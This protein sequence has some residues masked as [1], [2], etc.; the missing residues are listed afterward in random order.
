[1]KLFRLSVA[2]AAVLFATS[3]YPQNAAYRPPTAQTYAAAPGASLA[4][5]ANSAAAAVAQFLSNR[6]RDVSE[7]SLFEVSTSNALNN[8]SVVRFE[9]RAGGLSI[10]GVYAK[11]S[12]NARGE[13]IHLIENLVPARGGVAAARVSAAQ[14]LGAALREHYG[15][16]VALPPQARAQGN[17]TVFALTPFF[18]KEPTVTRVAVAAADGPMQA[19]LLVET[20]SEQG[21]LLHHTLVSGDGAI[22][23]VE[24]RTNNESYNVFA[25]DPGMSNQAVVTGTNWLSAVDQTTLKITGPNVR[26]YLD[27]DANNAADSGGALVINGEF[28]TGWNGGAAPGTL[29]NKAVA[30]Q[31]LFYLNNVM[32]DVLKGYGFT[33]AAGNFEGSDPVNAEAQDGGGTDNANFSTPADGSSPRMQMYLWTNGTPNLEV[34]VGSSRF[35]GKG[36][37][38][39][40]TLNLTG[41]PGSLAVSSVPDACAKP[42]SLSGQIAIIDRGT[43]T[44]KKKVANVQAAGAVAA[45]IVNNDGDRVMVMGNDTKVR[46]AIVIPSIFVGQSD[47]ATLRTLA[48]QSATVRDRGLTLQMTDASLDS[49]VVYHEYGHGLTWRMIGGMSGPLAGAIGEGASDGVSLL[50]N[51]GDRIGEYSSGDANGIRRHPYAGYPN[52]YANVTGSEVHDDGEVFGAIVYDLKDRFTL[53]GVPTSTLFEYFVDGMNFTPSTPAFEQ[54]RDGMLQS[55]ANA[56]GAH[57][58]LIWSSFAKFGVGVGAKGTTRGNRV[59]VA[60]SFTRP[61]GCN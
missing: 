15:N 34:A 4:A 47:G 24:L 7:S 17:A 22:L 20:W 16:G 25:V 48:G 52:T 6:G 21:N 30:V 2:L 33:T 51:D 46:T 59:T 58:C 49:D 13:L 37:E 42:A 40:P 44:F 60:E 9:Q 31:N 23:A 35:Y 56:G 12:F 29:G 11:A 50:M 5:R 10:Y 14:A 27:T 55:A 8:V 39:G 43:C 41:V 26:A 61:A 32:H 19:G 18:H 36:A 53:A 57:S 45:I 38:F 1:M 54:M 28:T 3:A